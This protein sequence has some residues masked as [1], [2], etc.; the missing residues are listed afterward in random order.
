MPYLKHAP[1]ILV[2]LHKEGQQGKKELRIDGEVETFAVPELT[3]DDYSRL[4]ALVSDTRMEAIW[5]N[6]S[7]K[8]A[9]SSEEAMRLWSECRA[10]HL[11]W[12]RSSKLSREDHKKRHRLIARKC[13]E[14]AGL[15]GRSAFANRNLIDWLPADIQP[16]L[17]KIRA[18]GPSNSVQWLTAE[19]LLQEGIATY[20]DH[21]AEWPVPMR[22]P[23]SRKAAAHYFA[24]RLLAYFRKHY[25][26]PRHGTVAVLTE[27][28]LGVPV[29]VDDV[30][31]ADKTASAPHA[32]WRRY[33]R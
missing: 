17:I 7:R 6:L 14:L 2:C 22:K 8:H 10:A 25:G 9:L 19:N 5:K 29:H 1:Q 28:Y 31:K 21:V 27:V 4:G 24:R 15:I 23:G 11:T 26:R 20:A 3:D 13:E 33:Y 32:L 16:E 18:L 30:K 12:L